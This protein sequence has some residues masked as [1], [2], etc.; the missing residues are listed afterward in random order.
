MTM[1][2]TVPKEQR[3]RPRMIVCWDRDGRDSEL[4]DE[5]D[6]FRA[7]SRGARLKYLA[8]LG[9]LV[10]ARGA[11]LEGRRPDGQLVLPAQL[12]LSSV[13]ATLASSLG[14][15]SDVSAGPADAAGAGL[16]ELL[17]AMEEV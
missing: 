8:R 9:L 4:L 1:A 14:G 15:N 6:R 17:A 11:H 10:E 12:G 13:P 5:L 3:S 7:R 16:D 2:R